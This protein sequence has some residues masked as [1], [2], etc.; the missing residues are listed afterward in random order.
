MQQ[1]QAQVVQPQAVPQAQ[2]IQ[3]Q[4]MQAQVVQ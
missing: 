4:V 1:P 2:V 3:P